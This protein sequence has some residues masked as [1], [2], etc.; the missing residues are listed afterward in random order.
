MEHRVPAK[1]SMS[2]KYK[3]GEKVDLVILRKTDL[4]FVAR[5]NEVDEGLLYHSEIFE[6]LERGDEI[7]GYIKKVREDGGIDLILQ[8]LGHRGADDIG[9][10][11]LEALERNDGFLPLTDKTPPEKIYEMFGVSKKKYKMALG[12]LYKRRLIKI[13]DAGIGLVAGKGR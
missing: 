2:D 3:V 11:I 6:R 8:P 12:G 5:I 1:A 13:T 4:G 7:H 9:E 10:R